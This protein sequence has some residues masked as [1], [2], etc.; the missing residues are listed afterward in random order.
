MRRWS[1]YRQISIEGL[2]IEKGIDRLTHQGVDVY[3]VSREAYNKV[4]IT[5]SD[6]DIPRVKEEFRTAQIEYMG[7]YGIASII[8]SLLSRIG[9]LIGVVVSIVLFSI[10]N[11]FT[12]HIEVVGLEKIDRA[13]VL[14]AVN[15]YGIRLGRI[16]NIENDELERYILGNVDG[17]S[18][19]SSQV[20]GTTLVINIKEE[21]SNIEEGPSSYVSPYNMIIN[22]FHVYSGISNMYIGQ[23]V[24]KGDILIY[25]EEYRDEDG[26]LHLVAPKA[27]ISATIWHIATEVFYKEEIV[28][29]RT[30]NAVINFAYYMGDTKIMEQT[31]ANSFQLYESIN[32]ET[33]V[34]TSLLPIRYLE[35][36]YYEV[37]EEVQQNDFA[38][39]KE[40]IIA[41]LQKVVYNNVD[42]TE[43]VVDEVVDVVE[44]S[45]RYIV[46]VYLECTK[47]I[48][49]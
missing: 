31:A 2:N 22:D 38:N 30:G 10:L 42:D 34:S 13:L 14:D 5:I 27:E 21:S 36:T 25:A 47:D 44:L 26:V 29:V 32:R 28:N 33:W 11:A 35:T 16:N 8:F 1:S 24:K 12:L 15:N 18:L 9:I 3:N 20:V 49:I 40:K 45:D 46:N 7:R 19:V 6:R 43:T 23:I 39:S 48:I 37:V 17:I 41:N 4:L